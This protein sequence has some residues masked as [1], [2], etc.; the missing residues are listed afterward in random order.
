M[1]DAEID[2]PMDAGV[3]VDERLAPDAMADSL[4]DSQ[5][6][7]QMPAPANS[8]RVLEP[9]PI[10][11]DVLPD[12]QVLFSAGGQIWLQTADETVPLGTN[13]AELRSAALVDD[14]ILILTA[15]GLLVAAANGLADSPLNDELEQIV[16]M[17]SDRKGGAW[18]LDDGGVSH[19]SD[20]LLRRR[21]LTDVDL[22]FQTARSAIGRYLDEDVI[23]LSDGRVLMAIGET[24]AWRFEWPKPLDWITTSRAGLWVAT[25]SELQLL[26]PDGGLTVW[27][28]PDGASTGLGSPTSDNLWLSSGF[29]LYQ[30]DGDALRERPDAPD[31][32]TLKIDA[33]GALY[34][35]TAVGIEK[36]LGRR[37]VTISGLAD[38]D[39]VTTRTVITIDPSESGS[40]ATVKATLDGLIDVDINSTEGWVL[41]LDPM[42]VGPGEHQLTVEIDYTDGL[43]L[44]QTIAFWGPPAWIEDIEPISETY[45]I[46]CHGDG[47]SAHRMVS[48]D[49]WM[50]EITWIIDDI[51]TGRMPYGLPR[52]SDELIEVVRGWQES[53]FL[54]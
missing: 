17:K 43:V 4:F 46:A 48:R 24:D 23:W 47:G 32:S 16:E 45:C 39:R 7:E 1:I 50:A 26:A 19:W 18:F 29:V 8:R 2:V 15:S 41:E 33:G 14:E 22:S 3:L 13:D 44:E 31:H 28:K 38:E 11:W 54:E 20:G 10:N 36:V 53:G 25:G 5:L 21:T 42:E 35:A 51:E 9:K 40:V 52:L 49:T 6:P 30:W 37:F 34:L 12:G 27:A